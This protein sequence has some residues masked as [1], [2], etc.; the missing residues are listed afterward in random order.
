MGHYAKRFFG[1]QQGIVTDGLSLYFDFSNPLCLNIQN[2]TVPI[3]TVFNDLSG[4]SGAN[5]TLATG[6]ATYNNGLLT[7]STGQIRQINKNYRTVVNPA[8]CT[9]E[10]IINNIN[11][12]TGNASLFHSSYLLVSTPNAYFRLN[13]GFQT[14]CGSRNPQY[15]LPTILNENIVTHIVVTRENNTEKI[16]INGVLS[17]TFIGRGDL[18]NGANGLYVFGGIM[19]TNELKFYELR[20]YNN[21]LSDDK[22]LQNYNA[23][24][25]KYGL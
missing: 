10:F 16:Y 5:A 21:A 17:N 2:G 15:I 3:N 22:V 14:Y 23:T 4:I 1:Q 7:T 8:S 9:F 12:S 13:N 24:K 19:G 6:L 25:H 11:S 20:V 18:L